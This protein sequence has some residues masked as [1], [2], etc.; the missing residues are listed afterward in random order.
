M[1][2]Y[3]GQVKGVRVTEIHW[4]ILVRVRNLD[5]LMGT[6]IPDVIQ[7]GTVHPCLRLVAIK[8]Y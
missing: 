3:Q 2:M 4:E 8:T 7:Y 5:T 6:C 1:S